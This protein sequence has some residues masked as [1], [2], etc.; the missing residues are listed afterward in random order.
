[1]TNELVFLSGSRVLR[2]VVLGP[3]AIEVGSSPECDIALE[4]PLVPP[5]AYLIEERAG[6]SQPMPAAAGM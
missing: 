1:M 6:K 3:K 5:R 4:H 2:Q